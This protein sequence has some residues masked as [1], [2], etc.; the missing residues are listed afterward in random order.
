[1][2]YFHLSVLQVE[3]IHIYS[4]IT[5][6]KKTALNYESL[7]IFIRSCSFPHQLYHDGLLDMHPVFGLVEN[8]GMRTI[9]D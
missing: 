7:G 6:Y 1:M 8:D 4:A 5:P 3:I 9:H 2:K